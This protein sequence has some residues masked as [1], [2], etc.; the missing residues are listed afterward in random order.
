VARDLEKKRQKARQLVA[1]A[2]AETTT[3]GERV[4]AA[5]AACSIISRYNLLTPTAVS[6]FDSI[7]EEVLRN[8]PNRPAPETA[9]ASVRTTTSVT[10]PPVPLDAREFPI[11][12]SQ[13]CESCHQKMQRG[14]L[15]MW[16]KGMLFH[17]I[18]WIQIY[19]P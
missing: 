17:R 12:D 1:L 13:Y 6:A 7:F 19:G 5:L 18:C 10:R 15:A 4:A 2:V 8:H 14:T 3:E 16:S 9:A 11:I